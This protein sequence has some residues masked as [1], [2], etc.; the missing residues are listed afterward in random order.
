VTPPEDIPVSYTPQREDVLLARAFQ[1]QQHGFFID[2]GA[3]HPVHGSTTQLLV[4][5]GWSGINV[6][7]H[8]MFAAAFARHRPNDVNLAVAVSDAPG[9][10]EFFFVADD[11]ALTTLDPG[12]GRRYREQGRQVERKSVPCLTLAQICETHVGARRID[13]VSIDVEG[14]EERVLAGADF[15]RWRPRLL[16]L[17]AVEPYTTV[18]THGRWEHLI[19]AHGYACALFDGINR[20]YVAPG[21]P[22]L[23]TRLAYPVCSLDRYVSTEALELRDYRRLG[24]VARSTARLTQSIVDLVQRPTRRP[25]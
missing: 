10:I 2:I 24:R 21:E 4:D 18:Q 22:D 6:E 17:E 16:M 15:V 8:P 25:S 19:L 9:A 20:F 12:L 14:A 5:R 1:G 3:N 13:F 7:P 11:P 23:L